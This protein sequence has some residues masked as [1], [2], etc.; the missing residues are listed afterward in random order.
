M[1]YKPQKKALWIWEGYLLLAALL[2]LTGTVV[3]FTAPFPEW[4]DWIAIAA[5]IF[6]GV[7][8]ALYLFFSF[9]YLP[10]YFHRMSYRLTDD[11]L[12]I[13]TG[14]IYTHHKVMPYASVKY[15]TSFQGPLERLWGLTSVTLFASGSFVVLHGLS[16]ED[17]EALRKRLF[18]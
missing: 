3:L 18:P 7:W 6:T 1:T 12:E 16:V 9:V 14:V 8:I 2:P 5:W 17:G 11:R 13:H 4:M 15:L 10:V